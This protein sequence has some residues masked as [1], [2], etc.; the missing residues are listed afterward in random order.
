MKTKLSILFLQEL[1]I[2]WMPFVAQFNALDSSLIVSILNC[3]DQKSLI[4][5][6]T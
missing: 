5:V 4:E 2:I 1:L 3:F 6:A